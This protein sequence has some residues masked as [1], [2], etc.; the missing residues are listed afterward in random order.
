MALTP[1]DFLKNL[2]PA[3]VGLDYRVADHA[4]ESG[5]AEKGL[6][7]SIRAL[8]PRRLSAL[9]SLPHSEVRIDFRGYDDGERAAFLERFDRAFQRGGG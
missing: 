2:G 1:E 5:S 6:S 7:I 9:L 3:M 8:P 4:V